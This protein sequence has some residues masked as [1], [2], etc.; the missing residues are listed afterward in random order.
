MHGEFMEACSYV[1]S[2]LALKKL[3]STKE[4]SLCAWMAVS[5]QE[6]EKVGKITEFYSYREHFC[7]RTA[8]YAPS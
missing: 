3:C 8:T 1:T 6:E 4:K 7:H 2:E 5:Q